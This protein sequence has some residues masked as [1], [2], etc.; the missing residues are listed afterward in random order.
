[1]QALGSFDVRRGECR[2]KVPQ[3]MQALIWLLVVTMVEQRGTVLSA[4]MQL[5]LNRSRPQVLKG[6]F[7]RICITKLCKRIGLF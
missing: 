3:A 5:G 6:G 1:M 2:V 4:A 7:Q